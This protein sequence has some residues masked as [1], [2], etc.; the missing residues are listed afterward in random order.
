MVMGVTAEEFGVADG[1]V[2]MGVCSTVSLMLEMMSGP[3][4]VACFLLRFS[5]G[6]I[7]SFAMERVWKSVSLYGAMISMHQAWM[8]SG[9]MG[10][11]VTA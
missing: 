9:A 5:M 1:G 7:C 4:A 2:R 6:S 8:A 10:S 11:V 3:R